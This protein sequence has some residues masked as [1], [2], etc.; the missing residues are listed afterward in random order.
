[1]GPFQEL[2][3]LSPSL[4]PWRKSSGVLNFTCTPSSGSGSGAARPSAL[5]LPSHVDT[6]RLQRA[7]NPM[8]SRFRESQQHAG[9]MV[10]RC[11]RIAADFAE[12]W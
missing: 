7:L 6:D 3:S 2:F 8:I 9:M 12:T 1:M 10:E 11:V 5:A 4:S